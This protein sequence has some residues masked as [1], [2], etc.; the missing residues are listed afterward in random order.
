MDAL[1]TYDTIVTHCEKCDL[2][3][4]QLRETGTTYSNPTQC[5]YCNAKRVVITVH[6]GNVHKVK[7]RT[8]PEPEPSPQIKA[9]QELMIANPEGID[10]NDY[11][12]DEDGKVTKK[13]KSQ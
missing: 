12:I 1:T 8:E 2:E 3:R 10:L 13:G 7:T 5:G 6:S 9:L 4:T 11:Q